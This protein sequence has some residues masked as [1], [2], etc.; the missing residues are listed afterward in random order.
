M[1]RILLIRPGATDFDQQHRILGTLDVPLSGDGSEQVAELIGRL[2]DVR[3]DAIYTSPSQCAV[4]TAEKIAEQF[5]VKPKAIA[6]L[7][8]VDHG[9]WQGLLIDEVKRKQPKVFRQWKEHPESV[10]P[11]EG[12]M[13][14]SARQRVEA[15]LLKLI[16]KHKNETVGLIAPEPLASLIGNVLQQDQIGNVSQASGSGRRWEVIETLGP[17]LTV[18]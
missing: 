11:P 5:E 12:E 16:K 8:N 10:C 13:L 9:L 2:R 7:S 18:A 1:V 15:S 4:E 6:Q 14:A 3:F 17:S